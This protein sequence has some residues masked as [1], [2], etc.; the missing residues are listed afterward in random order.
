MIVPRA[1]YCAHGAQVSRTELFGSG[2]AMKAMKDTRTE[3]AWL[4]DIWD[5]GTMCEWSILSRDDQCLGKTVHMRRSLG[6][7]AQGSG[8]PLADARGKY[9]FRL[10]RARW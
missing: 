6:L 2:R 10:D 8:L 3:W 4:G 5:G 7:C 1:H 9:K